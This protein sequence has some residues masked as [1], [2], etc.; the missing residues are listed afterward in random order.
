MGRGWGGGGEWER[1]REES[2]PSTRKKKQNDFLDILED[3]GWTTLADI[4]ETYPIFPDIAVFECTLPADLKVFEML[5]RPDA[6]LPIVCVGVAR[7]RDRK[8]LSF[9]FINLN[10]TSS[11]FIEHPPEEKLLEVVAVSQLERDTVLVCFGSDVKVVNLNGRPKPCRRLAT[12][13]HF[14]FQVE[15]LVV[16]Q[17]SVL[18][19][20]KHGMQGRSFRSNEVT[21]EICD[22]SKLFSLLG[23]DKLIVLKSYP[24]DDPTAPCNLYLLTGHVNMM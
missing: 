8:H 12:E 17:D 4:Q 2:K 5:V 7:G 9:D 10:S 13:L 22:N 14:D 16:L 23:S 1:R 6:D 15:N 20:Y 18:A 11:W 21:Q 3:F 19:F 24:T